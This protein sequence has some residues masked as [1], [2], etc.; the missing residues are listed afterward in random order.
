MFCESQQF[1]SVM[2]CFGRPGAL[3]RSETRTM[4]IFLIP[5]V[6][7]RFNQQSEILF[8]SC[9]RGDS[10]QNNNNNGNLYSAGICHVVA[11]MALLHN[12][13]HQTHIQDHAKTILLM[14]IK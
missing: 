8:F 7:F 5:P 6:D 11:L 3:W 12:C 1:S 9:S 10:Q 14:L 2:L 4:Q 13:V